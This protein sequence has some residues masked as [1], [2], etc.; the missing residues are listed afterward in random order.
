M[1]SLRESLAEIEHARWS[2]WQANVH[3][4]CVVNSDGSLTVPA[5]LAGRW[6]RRVA[7]PYAEL[8]EAEKDS[9]RRDADD[10]LRLLVRTSDNLPYCCRMA[11]VQFVE[12]GRLEIRVDEHECCWVA[13]SSG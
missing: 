1:Q 3:C 11:L 9:H 4:Q 2:R 5:A 7:T 8:T 13:T 10:T 12:D 6:R